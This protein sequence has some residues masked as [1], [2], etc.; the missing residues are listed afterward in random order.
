MVKANLN[1]ELRNVIMIHLSDGN[2]DEK[3]FVDEMKKIVAGNPY[4]GVCAARKGTVV[5]LSLVPF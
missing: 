1:E 3:R 5:D 2:S 4:S